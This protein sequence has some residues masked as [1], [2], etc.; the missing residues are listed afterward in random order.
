MKLLTLNT[1]S[2][3]EE[4]YA[5]KLDWFIE[6]ILKEQPDIIALQEVNQTADAELADAALWEGQYLLPAQVPLRQDNHAAQVALRLRQAGIDCFWAWLPIKLGY[7]KYDE[8]IAILSLG[9]KITA[10]EAFPISQVN[11]Y[12]NWRTRAAL[13]V[14]VEG[15]EDWFYTVHMGWWD[16]AEEPFLNQWNT[17]SRKIAEKC[18]N[19][20][21]W[22]MGDFNAPDIVSGQSFEHILTCGWVDTYQVALEKDRSVTVPG[23]IDGWRDKSQNMRKP[24]M[25]L[26]YI[27]CNRRTCIRSS[28]VLFNG[29]NG[30]VVSDHFGVLITTK[31]KFS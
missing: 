28:R 24:E 10:A 4:N 9:R 29:E 16:D 1:H 21:V 20:F 27:F 19:G 14:Q 26:D 11:D 30:P 7:G 15:M 5:Q 18:E 6:G 8:G 2:L 3:Q 12:H 25:R 13:G 31:E 17:L 23:V 22:L